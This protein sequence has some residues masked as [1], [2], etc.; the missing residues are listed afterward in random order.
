MKA[1]VRRTL[2]CLG[3]AYALG[4]ASTSMVAGPGS[5][6]LVDLTGNLSYAGMY[7]A[8]VYIGVAMGAGI[9]GRAMD[10]LGR[11]PP[12]ITAYLLAAVGYTLAGIGV[13]NRIVPLFVLGTLCFAAANGTNNLTRVAAAEMFESTERGR[14]V[15]WI[16]IAAVFGAVVGPLLLVLSGP[17]GTLLG[18]PPL[19]LVWF[20]APPLHLTAAFLVSRAT[21]PHS[22][23]VGAATTTHPA[24]AG[25]ASHASR[26][27]LAGTIVLIASQAAMAS[28]MGVAGAAVSHAGH[29]VGV[30]GGLMFLH[31]VGMFGLSRVVGRVADVAGRRRT[32]FTGL[33]LL[34]TGGL[35]VA[36]VPGSVG[37]GIGLLLVGF[38]WSFG[39]I[40][41]TVL[42]TDVAES[43][44][45]ARTLGRADLS[46]QL[47]SALI[48]SAGGWWFASR[49]L[50]GLGIAAAAV[51]TLPVLF[52]LL[53]QERQPG[54]YAADAVVEPGVAG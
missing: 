41:G 40:G 4:W 26:L 37:F 7:V 17:L 14:G 24:A 3:A 21:E 46:A 2:A 20:F 15:A 30:L 32:I 39:Y 43:E 51:A 23:A 16:Q 27:V 22:L 44:H 9:G 52:V 53:V 33:G 8:M 19:T 25:G 45:R 6:A 10:R 49:G 29:G 13:A 11:K 47:S 50:A 38:G 34:A 12:L 42:L 36:F 18:R 35:V 48:A 1:E 54:H 28:V 31:F 5:A